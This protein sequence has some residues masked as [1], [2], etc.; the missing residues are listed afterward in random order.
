M[1]SEEILCP[2]SKCREGAIL[3]GIV[4]RDGRVAF[5]NN[6]II[7]NQEFVQI[8][9]KG[10]VPEKRFRF[11]GKCLKNGCQQWANNRCGV[12]DTVI[13][14]TNEIVEKPDLPNCSIRSKCRWYSQ[15]GAD[16]CRV[17]P[18]IVTDLRTDF[19]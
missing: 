9:D 2:S 1:N 15:S 18:D 4:M 12:I 6:E 19:I 16:A 10:R 5:S 7:I 17:C 3:V 13:E 14:T 8:A 11:G